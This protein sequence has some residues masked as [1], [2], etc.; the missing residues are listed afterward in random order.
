VVSIGIKNK[1]KQAII[2]V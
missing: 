1:Q 2:W